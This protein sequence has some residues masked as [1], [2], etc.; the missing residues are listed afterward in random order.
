MEMVEDSMSIVD[1]H[2][3]CE[4]QKKR[5]ASEVSAAN[6]RS[7]ISVLLDVARLNAI[8]KEQADAKAE[9]YK[10]QDDLQLQIAA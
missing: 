6:K 5:F 1:V 4:Q 8:E 9:R 10:L 3:L 7:T 2:D